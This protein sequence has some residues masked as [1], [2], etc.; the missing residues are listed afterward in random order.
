MTPLP[1]T[2]P[3]LFVFTLFVAIFLFARATHYSRIALVVLCIWAILQTVLGLTGFYRDTTTLT[4][5][6]PLLVGP[7][8][9]FYASLF[10]FRRGRRFIDS[11]DLRSL[12]LIHVIRVGVE[13]VLLFLFLHHGIPKA[14]TLEGRNIDILSGL[15]APIV[16]YFFF[17]RKN[18][19]PQLLAAWHV[20]CSLF[21]LSV[22]STA[23]LS[24][25]ARA[26]SFGF[27]QANVAVGYFPYLLL[28]A[29][30]VP[31]ILF[32]HAAAV[33]QLVLQSRTVKTI[34]HD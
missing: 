34:S 4:G 22:V 26:A 18:L 31:T 27:A 16:Y 15:S 30:L 28:P 29:V 17:I 2:I 13:I 12:T 10:F 32:C 8:V 1:W 33:R 9:I 6:F 20:L 21:L 24:L 5:R 19:K 11:L 3:L 7:P 23:F 25:P 14:M